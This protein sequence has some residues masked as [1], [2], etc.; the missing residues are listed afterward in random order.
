[1]N[2]LGRE[3][4]ILLSRGECEPSGQGEGEHSGQGECEPSWQCRDVASKELW[5]GHTDLP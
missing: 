3:K 4:V 2:L 5:S 1:M